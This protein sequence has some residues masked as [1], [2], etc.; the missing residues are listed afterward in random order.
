MAEL[1]KNIL[2]DILLKNAIDGKV[3]SLLPSPE[4]S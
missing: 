1:L 4:V 2:G 3:P